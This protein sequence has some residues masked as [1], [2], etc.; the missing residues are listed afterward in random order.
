MAAWELHHIKQD[1]LSL[2]EF[3]ARLR[4]LVKE[5]NY[6]LAQHDRFLR[7]FLV[8]GMSSDK[9]RKSPEVNHQKLMQSKKGSGKANKVSRN[10]V[11]IKGNIY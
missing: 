7:D 4:T 3:I 11:I 9:V 10:L 1:N 5:A 6:P 8:I 2:E